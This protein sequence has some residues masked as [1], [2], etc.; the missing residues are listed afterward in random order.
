M[1]TAGQPKLNIYNMNRLKF[2]L[3][4]FV[5]AIFTLGMYSCTKDELKN[6]VYFDSIQFSEFNSSGT[7]LD[8]T[9]VD[10]FIYYANV[11]TNILN[12]SENRILI[13]DSLK[14]FNLAQNSG[15][16]SLEEYYNWVH[17]TFGVSRN[18]SEKFALYSNLVLP[19]LQQENIRN[20]PIADRYYFLLE[21]GCINSNIQYED[22]SDYLRRGCG[23]WS[24]FGNTVGLAASVA[25][26]VTT[27]VWTL[28]TGTA[29]A[30][31][32]GISAYSYG[33]AIAGCF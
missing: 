10:S 6:N 15:I 5:V 31:S 23:F 16:N 11:F 4:N 33:T 28:G 8:T 25:G 26:A 12:S 30:I 13:K 9:E 24:V 21:S 32:L 1:G 19:Q 20:H 18:I 14:L 3:A 17:I 2:L 22:F 7:C 27:E 29:V